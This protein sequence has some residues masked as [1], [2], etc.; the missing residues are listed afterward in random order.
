MDAELS[1][2]YHIAHHSHLRHLR[3]IR[4]R[5]GRDV[6]AQLVCALVLS[7]LDYC[8]VVLWPSRLFSEFSIQRSV[9]YTSW[10]HLTTVLKDMH[11][12]PI[13]QR[14]NYKLGTLV[15]N[16]S[17]DRAPLYMS[18]M[19]SA[20]ANVP[21]L[22][23]LCIVQQWLRGSEDEAKVRW[24]IVRRRRSPYLEQFALRTQKPLNVPQLSN[25]DKKH[26]LNSAYNTSWLCNASPVY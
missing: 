4:M 23:R 26:F 24:K 21:S 7:R 14:V 5:L 12:L 16:V 13:K 20:C 19:L 9:S 18:D 10:S 11:W 25:D 1:M 6:T 15:H 3:S 17:T 22:A 2:C 8:N